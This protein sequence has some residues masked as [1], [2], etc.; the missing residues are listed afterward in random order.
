MTSQDRNKIPPLFY[1]RGEEKSPF[2]EG[3]ESSCCWWY[4]KRWYEMSQNEPE[5]LKDLVEEYRAYGLKDFEKDD[6]VPESL[7]ALLWN[8]Y[9]YFGYLEKDSVGFKKWYK[10]NYRIDFD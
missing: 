5:I 6:F 3:S 10:N 7:K 8:R 4:E 1:Y 2:M 9:Y